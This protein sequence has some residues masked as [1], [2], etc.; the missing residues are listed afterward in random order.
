MKT[1]KKL[2]KKEKVVGGAEF[3]CEAGALISHLGSGST[4]LEPIWWLL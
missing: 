3:F 4:A 1:N 2:E